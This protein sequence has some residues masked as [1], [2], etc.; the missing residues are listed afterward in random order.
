MPTN[1]LIK[2]LLS[3]SLY[4][5]P[6]SQTRLIETHV[7][8]VI[9]TGKYAYKIKKTVDFGFLDFST[10][11]KRKHFCEE[12]LRLGQQFASEIYLNVVPIT[13]TLDHPQIN[14]TGPILEYAIKMLEFPQ[15]NLLSTLLKQGGLTENIIDQLSKLIAEF[16]Q[17]TPIAAKESRF[18]QPEE[19]HAPSK[20]NF[21]QIAPLLT[22]PTDINQLK[23][24]E[25]WSEQQFKQLQPSLQ[26]RKDH[27]FIRDCHGDLHLANIIFYKNKPILFDRLEFNEDLRW[28]DVIAD[29]AFLMMDLTEKKQPGF[30]NQLLNTYL[31]YTGDYEGLALLP[32]YLTYRAVVRAKI[33]LFRLKQEKLGDEEK[34]EIQNDYY[35]FI[36]LAES[37]TQPVKPS[38]IITH[39]FAGSGKTTVAKECVTHCGAIQ[40]NS[41][42]IRKNLFD[43]PL[44]GHSNSGL[45]SGI[46]TAEATKET[47]KKLS[48]LTE[49]IIKAGFTTLVDA[50]FLQHSQRTCFYSLAKKM[51]IPFYILH[52]QVNNTE[53]EQRIKR[54]LN[55]PNS[56]SE[57]DLTI[58]IEQ[59]KNNEPLTSL[60]KEHTLLIKD[61]QILSKNILDKICPRVHFDALS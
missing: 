59:K 37:Y 57:A 50:T 2:N 53:I 60:E 7:S 45:N 40:I 31:H 29:L 36:N 47:Y 52:C 58:L 49:I 43:I 10:L 28:T 42:I 16:H 9:L 54:R 48:D 3:N 34:K 21:E 22:N 14:G 4:E 30:A 20:Q 1:V 12:E 11:E 51:Q 46:Y 17:K 26:S 39:G 55:N 33:A 44:H 8:W 18:G 13:G 23:R 38:L 56:D 6:V 5:H 35:N 27:G 15:E 61:K 41:D 25:I 19:V 32:Y 24:L